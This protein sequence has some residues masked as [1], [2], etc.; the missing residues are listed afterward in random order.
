[1]K[2]LLSDYK[3]LFTFLFVLERRQ[4]EGE[5]GAESDRLPNLM[6]KIVQIFYFYLWVAIAR[7]NF[8]WVNILDFR[9]QRIKGLY[10]GRA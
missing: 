1:M 10:S 4:F 8:K 6:S 3:H 7:H 2:D 5:I 9:I